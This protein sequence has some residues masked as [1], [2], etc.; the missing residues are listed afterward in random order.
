MF[1]MV[2]SVDE[3][4]RGIVTMDK[5]WYRQLVVINACTMNLADAEPVDHLLQSQ[6][7]QGIWRAML[8]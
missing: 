7:A 8:S 5:L 6:F 4:L 3:V 1:P 2:I